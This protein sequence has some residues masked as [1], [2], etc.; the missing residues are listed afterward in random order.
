MRPDLVGIKGDSLYYAKKVKKNTFFPYNKILNLILINSFKGTKHC[1]L[2]VGNNTKVSYTVNFCCSASGSFLPAFIIYKAKKMYPTW[3]ENGL[4]GA[5]YSI[6]DSGWMESEQFKLWFSDIFL[7]GTK[8]LTG[9]KILF[10]DG[11]GS[12]ISLELIDLAIK[13]NVHLLCLPAHS[14]AHFQ[15][16]DVAVYK[17]V[18]RNWKKK[19]E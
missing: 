15:P 17:E 11:H 8:N 10:Y 16:L 3:T 7:E 12:H 9:P 1:S 4:N 19:L 18:K 2:L 5:K 13:N 14:S 6:S